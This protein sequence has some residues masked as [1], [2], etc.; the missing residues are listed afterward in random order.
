VPQCSVRVGVLHVAAL[1]LKVSS[2]L[3]ARKVPDALPV[4]V[5]LES[6][7]FARLGVVFYAAGKEVLD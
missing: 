2:K 4:N 7:A 6:L 3:R 5:L 1:L